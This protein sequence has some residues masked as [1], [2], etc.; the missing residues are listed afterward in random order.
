MSG[1]TIN[2]LLVAGGGAL[3]AVTR[4]LIAG[5]YN[6]PAGARF[7]WGTFVANVGG[8]FF[9]GLV[10]GWLA[11]KGAGHPWETALKYGVAT[12]YLGS[13]TTFST[14]K[15]E[16]HRF[17]TDGNYWLGAIYLTVTLLAGFAAVRLGVAGAEIL[18]PG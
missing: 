5:L 11:Q 2:L 7:P 18:A 6:D 17:V 14:L 1:N 12:G 4:F 13:L 15:F 16:T 3:G 10:G 9:L 8:A